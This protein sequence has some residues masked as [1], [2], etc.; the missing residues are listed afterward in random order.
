MFEPDLGSM[1]SMEELESCEKLLED[2]LDSVTNRKVC[3]LEWH[4]IHGFTIM[5]TLGTVLNG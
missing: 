3:V 4:M 1:T 5:H 2:L